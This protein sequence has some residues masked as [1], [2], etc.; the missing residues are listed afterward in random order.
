MARSG[1]DHQQ[2]HWKEHKADCRAAQAHPTPQTLNPEPSTPNPKP[3]TP[4]PQPQT[5]IP[6]PKPRFDSDR[7]GGDRGNVDSMVLE[8]LYGGRELHDQVL[9]MRAILPNWSVVRA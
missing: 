1:Q 7:H 5:L 8:A 9:N 4:N 6:T 2:A 3:Q